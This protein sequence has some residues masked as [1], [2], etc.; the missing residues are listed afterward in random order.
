MTKTMLP[1]S[2]VLP[3]ALKSRA[4]VSVNEIP[5]R[6][7]IPVGHID[8]SFFFHGVFQGTY[9]RNS[10]GIDVAG[11]FHP[12]VITAKGIVRGAGAIPGG[13]FTEVDSGVQSHFVIVSDKNY[14]SMIAYAQAEAEL[15]AKGKGFDYNLF[16]GNCADFAFRVFQHSDLPQ[17]YRWI[18]LYLKDPDEPVAIYAA[19]E[20]TMYEDGSAKWTPARRLTQRGMTIILDT[21]RLSAKIVTGSA[22]SPFHR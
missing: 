20:A 16:S 11:K 9:G 18:D 22:Q 12:Q 10:Q 6:G 7:Q 1:N 14:F 17:R 8:L 4:V 21:A 13:V 15:T 5:A 2:I 19:D 3:A